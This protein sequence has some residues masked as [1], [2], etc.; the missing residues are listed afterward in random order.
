MAVWNFMDKDQS[1]KGWH[2]PVFQPW[3]QKPISKWENK[4]KSSVTAVLQDTVLT[5][6]FILAAIKQLTSMK[7]PTEP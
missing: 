3:D 1:W 5:P 6:S 2:T 4:N 7:S